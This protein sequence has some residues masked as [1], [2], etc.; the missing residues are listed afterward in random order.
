[1][2]SPD[3]DLR[4]VFYLPP[5]GYSKMRGGWIDP[6]SVCNSPGVSEGLFCAEAFLRVLL[7]HVPDEVLRYGNGDRQTSTTDME[8]SAYVVKK[9]F[10]STEM[11]YEYLYYVVMILVLC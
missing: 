8:L 5:N 11:T 2:G 9:K 3:T 4:S 7:H 1:M 6:G 10:S